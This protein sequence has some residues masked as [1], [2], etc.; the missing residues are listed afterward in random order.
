MK[1]S[2]ISILEKIGYGLGDTASNLVFQTVM[3]FLAYF[4]TDIFGLSA[5]A[6]GT[7]FLVVRLFDGITDPIMGF[8]ADRHNSAHGKFR[9]FLLWIALPL[10]LACWLTFS[11][12]EF[13]ASGKLIYAYL[14]YAFLMLMYTAINIPYCAL[15]GV[16]TADP[17]Q[18]VSLQSYR[19]T[20][21]MLG[22][23][24]VSACTLPMV[25]FFGA[26]NEQAGY[27]ST[28]LIMS[29]IGALMFVVCFRTTRERVHPKPHQNIV[30][31]QALK[32]LW[33]ND[34]WRI[35]SMVCFIVLAGMVIRNTVALY[36]VNYYLGHKALATYFITLGMLGAI[37]GS[38]IVQFISQRFCKIKTYAA[39]NALAGGVCIAAFFIP[40]N[41]LVGAFA[42]HI[43]VSF[44][45]QVASPLLWS[46]MAD[47]VD[48]GEYKERIRVTG[49]T[50]SANLFFLKLGMAVGGAAAAWSLAGFGYQ[51]NQAQS[52]QA[53]WG[54]NFLFSIVPGLIFIASGIYILRYRLNNDAMARIHAN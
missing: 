20:L 17:Q 43:L 53:L 49:L 4:Y 7:M 10:V 6:V 40:S 12:P 33:R 27:Q 15:G 18:R 19:F 51:A 28:M 37:I 46:M 11:T 21:A 8:L 41:N 50:Y 13:T 38:F 29:G 14:T 26:G 31:K 9:P 45:L 42:G 54:I 16:I 23:L 52:L 5:A 44:L 36:Y 39:A 48:Y 22:G 35:I 25:E 1:N 34:Q 24:A 47:V 2:R 3:L 32:S 30:L